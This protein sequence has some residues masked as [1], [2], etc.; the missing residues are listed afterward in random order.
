MSPTAAADPLAQQYLDLAEMTGGFVHDLKNQLGTVLLNLQLLAEDFDPPETPRERRAV[1]RIHAMT[2]ECRRLV[3]L[4]NDFLRFARVEELHLEPTHLG[5]VVGRMIDFVGP[6]AKG[7][8]I[9]ID[10]YAAADLPA[11]PLDREMF[12]RVLLNLLLNAEDAMPDGGTL[13]LQAC[14][15]DGWVTL[16][17]IDTGCGIPADELGKL[18]K[19]FHTTKSGGTGLGLA[20]ARKVVAAHSG[21]ITVQSAVGR[22]TKFTIKLPTAE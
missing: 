14:G 15:D 5:E 6:T 4:S 8:G 17:V 1:D 16:D 20:T 21:T 2:D 10:W 18:F 3:G 12:E 22:G 13:T 9:D 19:P 11:V 7:K